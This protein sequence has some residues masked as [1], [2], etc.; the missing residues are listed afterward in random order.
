MVVGCLVK[1]VLSSLPTTCEVNSP[2]IQDLLL[3]EDYDSLPN[4]MWGLLIKKFI[5]LMILI[6]RA[7]SFRSWSSAEGEGYVLFSGWATQLPT[8]DIE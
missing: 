1:Q 3:E 4:L 7:G 2:E 6:R 8:L 5:S